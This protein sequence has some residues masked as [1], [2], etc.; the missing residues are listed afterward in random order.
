[1]GLPCLRPLRLHLP[2]EASRALSIPA[3]LPCC[4][5]PFCC[6]DDGSSVKLP[7]RQGATVFQRG[8][9][10]DESVG[11]RSNLRPCQGPCSYPPP[12]LHP[13][14]PSPPSPPPST[15][16]P[17]F[18]PLPPLPPLP[19]SPPPSTLSPPF[20]PSTLPSAPPLPPFFTPSPPLPPPFLH[21]P[22]SSP[23]FPHPLLSTLCSTSRPPGRS[24]AHPC[25]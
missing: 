23:P 5:C 10:Q 20:H 1:M 15:L 7:R 12:L 18:H 14:P 22:S 16:P 2:H 13:L 25:S 21:P 11:P 9:R 8:Q 3:Q 17:P 19:P 4:R 24:P 6:W